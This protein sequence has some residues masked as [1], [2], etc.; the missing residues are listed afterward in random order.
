MSD[1]TP[2]PAGL[3]GYFVSG[4]ATLI[5]AGVVIGL[6]RNEDEVAVQLLGATLGVIGTAITLVGT[7]AAGVVVGLRI[8]TNR[9]PHDTLSL[10]ESGPVRPDLD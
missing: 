5:G 7:I 4:L 10:P 9:G 8:A 1:Y 2:P 3:A 6:G